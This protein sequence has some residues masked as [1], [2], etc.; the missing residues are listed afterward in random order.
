V[1]R[2]AIIAG[3]WKMHGTVAQTRELAAGLVRRLASPTK[4]R[5]VVI[6][7]P[8]TSLAAAAEAVR[9]SVRGMLPKT[10]A[11]ERALDHGIRHVHVIGGREP[12][13]LTRVLLKNESL[14]TAVVN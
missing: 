14:G 7:P 10:R 11:C 9:R 1:S 4:G 5:Q 6:A 13:C 12:L 3:N 8:F 2:A